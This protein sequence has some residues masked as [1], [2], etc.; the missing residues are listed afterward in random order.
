MFRNRGKPMPFEDEIEE[1]A[2]RRRAADTKTAGAPG[3]TPC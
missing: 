3:V 1:L 2:R